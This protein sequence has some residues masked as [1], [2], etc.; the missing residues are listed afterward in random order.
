VL[1]TSSGYKHKPDGD[2]MVLGVAQ[3]RKYPF[4]LLS[5]RQRNELHTI[6]YTGS[7]VTSALVRQ[8]TFKGHRWRMRLSHPDK[9][10][11]TEHNTNLGHRVPL[12]KN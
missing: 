9:S 7:V 11:L 10:A 5:V 8:A 12:Q 4:Q 6:E 1:P 2:K 3:T